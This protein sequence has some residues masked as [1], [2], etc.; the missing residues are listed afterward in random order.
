MIRTII[1]IDEERCNGCGICVNACHEGAIGLVAGKAKLLR[2]DYCDGMGDCL[3]ECPM[4]A[5]SF[6]EREAPAYDEAAVI[7]AQ[8]AKAKAQAHAQASFTGCPGSAERTFE[9]AQGNDSEPTKDT[10]L[11]SELMQWPCQLKLINPQASCFS[12]S[13][14]LVAADC[15]AYAHGDFHRMFMKGKP[16]IIG[17]PKLDGV[18]YAEKLTAIFADNDISDV[19][20]TRME[21]P[22]CGGLEMAV[23]RAASACGRNLPVQVVTI[24]TNGDIIAS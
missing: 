12:G 14:V 9:R 6:V 10:P 20:V 18:D 1:E 21:V 4:G 17:C 16:T 5:I 15:C 8:M 3:P 11:Q 24:A 22:C 19:T 23:R 13:S 2:E 7:A